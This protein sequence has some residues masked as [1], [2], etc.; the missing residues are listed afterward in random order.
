MS[1]HVGFV[2]L[3]GDA[4]VGKSTFINSLMGIKILAVSDKPQTTRENIKAIY[5]DKDSQVIFIDTPGLHRPHG[6]LGRIYIKDAKQAF[7][8]ADSIIYMVDISRKPNEEMIEK[9]K[10]TEQPVFVILNKI[11]LLPSIAVFEARNKMYRDLFNFVKSDRIISIIATKKDVPQY[12]IE[13]LKSSLPLGEPYFPEDM[14]LDHPEE[15]VYAEFIKEKCMRL[16][17]DEVPHALHVRI[18]SVEKDY[19]ENTIDVTA[20]IIV[21]RTSERAIVVGKKGQMISK[22]RRYAEESIKGFTGLEAHLNLFVK[23]VPNWRQ[24]MKLIKEYG[25]KE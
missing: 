15:F 10:N 8:D 3:I 18:M 25:Y 7:S 1:K 2:A 9:L 4:N 12:F 14:L 19:D 23:V 5:N 17:Y 16:L 20:D 11:D 6:E 22:I 24:N 13:E 21:E